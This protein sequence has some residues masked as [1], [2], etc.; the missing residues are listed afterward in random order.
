MLSFV[1]SGCASVDAMKRVEVDFEYV[2]DIAQELSQ[3]GYR[4][5]EPLPEALM[6]LDYDEYRKIRYDADEY[7]WKNEGLPFS[8]GFFHPGFLHKDQVKVHEFTPT[9]AQRIRYLKE[10]FEFDDQELRDSMPSDLDYAGIRVGYSQ[11]D[12]TDYREVISFL[13]ASY[14]RGTG[15]DTRYGTSARGISIDTGL[16]KPEEFP[17]FTEV[18]LGKPL[19]TSNSVQMF[20]LLEGPSVTG[21]YEFLIRPGDSTITDVK[22]RLFFRDSVESVGIAP[23]TSMYWLGENR[24]GGESDYRPEVHDADGLLVMESDKTAVWRALDVGSS[25]R[26]SFF[27]VDRLQGFGLMQRDRRF[28][29]YQDLEAE[30]HKRPSVWVE[31]KGDWGDGF[32][33]LVEL[34]TSNEFEDNVVAFW[35]PAVLPESGDVLEYEYKIHWSPMKFPEGHADSHVVSTRK[36]VDPSYPGTEVFVIDFSVPKIAKPEED[37]SGEDAPPVEKEKVA[38]EIVVAAEGGSEVLESHVVWNKYS[39]TWRVVLR[40]KEIGP[41][42]AVTEVRCQLLFGDEVSSEEWAYQWTR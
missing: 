25:T 28:E 6:N 5:P 14:F 36:G 32:I 3:R 38:P 8:L 41:E 37:E 35:E 26:L 22:A 15:F 1:I 12:A 24:T 17:K 16:G 13:G 27:S 10:F 31:A 7:L 11:G 4:E 39:K 34:P 33:K 18:W 23:L 20:A 40:L 21:A 30:Y 29:S 9:H 19:T 2:A 42:H